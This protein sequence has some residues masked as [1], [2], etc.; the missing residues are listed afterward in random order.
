MTSDQISPKLRRSVLFM[1]GDSLR[2]ISKAAQMDVDSIVMD[3]EDG[4]ALNRK[5]EARRTVSEALR[6][7]DFG[8]SERLVRLNGPHLEADTEE[9]RRT[10]ADLAMT[11]EAHPDGYVL[12]KVATAGQVQAIAAYL[13]KAESEKGGA[14]GTIRLLVVVETALGIMNLKEIASASSR[15]EA[16]MFGAEDLA[17]SLGAT[18]TKAG[19]EVF[20]ARSAVVTAAAAYSLQ[21]IDMILTD[22]TDVERLEAECLFAR[23]MGYA[24][25]MAIHPRQVEIINRVFAPSSEEIAAALRLVQA[26]E[27]HQAEGTG[28]FELDGKMVDMPL[29][30][31]A[32]GVLTRARLAGLLDET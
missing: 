29:V 2:K 1:P 9:G 5:E 32:E 4:V 18:R 14:V 3:L 23:Q 22:L 16:L 26:H 11:V 7:L 31:T 17:G 25:K 30:R 28:A 10:L 13:D 12:P 21:A 15:L 6:T 20:Y 27:T 24:G 8:R 19:W